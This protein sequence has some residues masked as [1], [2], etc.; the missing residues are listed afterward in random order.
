MR[1]AQRLQKLEGAGSGS[2]PPLRVFIVGDDEPLPDGVDA[3][4]PDVMV[5]RL[6]GVKPEPR[7]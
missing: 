1:L 5:V 2:P 7:Q 6:V 3:D 4:A